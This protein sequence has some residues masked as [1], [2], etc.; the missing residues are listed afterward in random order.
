MS[1]RGRARLIG[2]SITLLIGAA[3]WYLAIHVLVWAARTFGLI[4]AAIGLS[5]IALVGLVLA[6]RAAWRDHR[7]AQ[8]PWREPAWEEREALR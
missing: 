7:K 2:W 1:A 4:A 8:Q 5:A 6:L 3:T